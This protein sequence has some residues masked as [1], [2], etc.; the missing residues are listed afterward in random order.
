M[1]YYK[2]YI[3]L[4]ITELSKKYKKKE[5]YNIWLKYDSA[6]AKLGYKLKKAEIVKKVYETLH[7]EDENVRGRIAKM[8]I[9]EDNDLKERTQQ[10]QER[11][12]KLSEY[13]DKITEIQS[14]MEDGEF[15]RLFFRRLRHIIESST[16]YIDLPSIDCMW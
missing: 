1:A 15:K 7:T 11:K 3:E 6:Q 13:E 8:H 10:Q 16:V 12:N 5:L 14:L 2:D 4:S 9:Q